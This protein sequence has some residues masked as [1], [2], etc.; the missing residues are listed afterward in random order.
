[1]HGANRLASNSLLGLFLGAGSE[2]VGKFIEQHPEDLT[3][4]AYIKERVPDWDVP[5]RFDLA[6]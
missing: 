2:D 3:G 1:M 4:R 5:G 6:L